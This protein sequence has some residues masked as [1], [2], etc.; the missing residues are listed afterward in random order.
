MRTGIAVRP[1]AIVLPLKTGRH[2]G[3]AK[4]KSREAFQQHRDRDPSLDAGRCGV[5]T[6]MNSVAETQML[7]G[8][9]PCRLF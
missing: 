2:P 9:V 3:S 1:R 5:E 7:I 6:E 4:S 8:T